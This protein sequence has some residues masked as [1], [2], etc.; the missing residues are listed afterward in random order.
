MGHIG[1][2][3][4]AFNF[5]SPRYPESYLPADVAWEAV[6]D[7][8]VSRS[9]DPVQS[10]ATTLAR[11]AR[12]NDAQQDT[13]F[14]REEKGGRYYYFAYPEGGDTAKLSHDVDR[15]ATLVSDTPDST[16]DD[17]ADLLVQEGIFRNKS[18]AVKGIATITVKG[19][20]IP[21]QLLDELKEIRRQEETLKQQ[22]RELISQLRPLL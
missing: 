17:L 5:L 9:K 21:A 8:I 20:S 13:R 19:Q 6:K 4:F 11:F 2:K 1:F 16:V 12:P 7:G 3:E 14:G 10:L 18:D 22:K 15:P